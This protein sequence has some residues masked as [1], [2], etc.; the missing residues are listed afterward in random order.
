MTVRTKRAV[1]FTSSSSEKC[2]N[3]VWVGVGVGVGVW[4][5]VGVCGCEIERERDDFDVCGRVCERFLMCAW[6][7][8]CVGML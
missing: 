1:S 5:W 3:F 2:L 6:I 8:M 4:V 7:L